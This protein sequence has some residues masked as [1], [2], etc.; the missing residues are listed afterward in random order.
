MNPPNHTRFIVG[1][2]TLLSAAAIGCGTYLLLKG[3]QSGELLA[4]MASSGLSGL[5]GFLG[6]KMA[7]NAEHNARVTD[8]TTVQTTVTESKPPTETTP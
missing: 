3:Y 2:I 8:P 6:G 5:I 7:S 1:S 4:Q